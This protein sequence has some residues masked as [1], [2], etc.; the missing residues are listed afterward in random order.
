MKNQ[1]EVLFAAALSLS[2]PWQCSGVDFSKPDSQLDVIIDFPPGSKFPCPECNTPHLAVHDTVNKSWRHLDFFQHICYLHARVPRIIC[3]SCGVR[4]VRVPWARPDSGFTLLFEALIIAMAPHMPVSVIAKQVRV[5]DTRLW[6]VLRHYVDEARELLD[7]HDVTALAMDETSRKRGHKYVT[8]V[9]DADRKRVLFATPGKDK[10]TIEK[11]TDDFHEHN[12]DPSAITSV[13]MD[14]SP[15]FI[16][17]SLEC[18]PNAEITFD[19]FHV[20]KMANEAMDKVR[21]EETRTDPTLKGSKYLWLT[22]RDKLTKKRQQT[23]DELIRMN[24]KTARAYHLV[25]GLRSYWDVPIEL[26]E[27]YLQRWYNWAIRSRLEPFKELARTVKQHWRGIVNY[28]TSKMT[29]GFMEG[30][31]SMVQAAKRKAKGYNNTDNFITIIYLIA[32]KLPLNV[33]T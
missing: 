27:G 25:L 9:A 15:S 24:D 30:I 6:R 29:T 11:F 13:C 3:P 7:F 32:G 33:P 19:R 4:L 10:K 20:M 18:F 21:Q 23:L 12:G 14:M 1:N 16:Q 5:H 28:H 26:A 22:R 8:L 2:P 31:N 17:A